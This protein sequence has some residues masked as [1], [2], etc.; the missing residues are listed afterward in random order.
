MDNTV[1]YRKFARGDLQSVININRV[2]LPEHY[3]D[4]FYTNLHLRFPDTF[5]VAEEKGQIIGYIMSRMEA[6]ASNFDL[7]GSVRKGHI[8]S[9]AVL[10]QNRHKG[11]GKALTT[12][13][14][15]GMRNYKAKECFLEVRATN[16]AAITLYSNLGFEITKT[17]PRYYTDGEEAHV[18]TKKL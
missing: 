5:Y 1:T 4:D 3:T 14:L 6:G 17:I 18:M 12:K 13:A 15:D 16:L 9:I 11:V 7:R 8:V 10:P 2:C